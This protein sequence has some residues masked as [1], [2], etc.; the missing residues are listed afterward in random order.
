M[1][2]L[3]E[4]RTMLVTALVVFVAMQ[5]L[6]TIIQPYVPVIL[7]AIVVITVSWLVYGR[8]TRL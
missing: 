7:G 5:V 8:I 2:Y 3:K 6:I 1:K 4:L